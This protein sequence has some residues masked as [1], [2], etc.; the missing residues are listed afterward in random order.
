MKKIISCCLLG[1]GLFATQTY[2]EEIGCITTA[3][4][5]IG[6]NHKVCVQVFDD[7]KV[8]GVACHISQARTG[9]LAGTFGVAEDPSQF[10]IACRQVGPIKIKNKLPDE[11][12]AFTEDTS[13]FFKE[14]RVTRLF[15]SKRN[16][17]VYVA[18]S[19]KLIDGAPANS[20][21]SV[22]IMPWSSQ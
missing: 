21:S 2:A 6:A 8:E 12:T 7:P 16:T 3:W 18:V 19:R 17:L 11:E 20:I 10:S 9:G 15:D 14:T 22:P 1:A 4:K 5:L 13:L